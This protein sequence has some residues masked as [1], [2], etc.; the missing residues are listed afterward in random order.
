M[1]SGAG[2]LKS[3]PSPSIL[4]FQEYLQASTML[5][6][7]SYMV[8][9]WRFTWELGNYTKGHTLMGSGELNRVSYM[10]DRAAPG[11]S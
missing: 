4:G 2:G 6:R 9:L 10:K 8:G 1:E 11:T 7:A 3:F 5:T